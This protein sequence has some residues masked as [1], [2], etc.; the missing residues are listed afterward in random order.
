MFCSLLLPLTLSDTLLIFLARFLSLTGSL[1]LSLARMLTP[2]GSLWLY[3]APSGSLWLPLTHSPALS[4]LLSV[5]HWPLWLTIALLLHTVLARL[6]R[7]LLGSQRRYHAD[8]LF[9]S[10]FFLTKPII[11]AQ[12]SS[13]TFN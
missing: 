11:L 5:S 3:L 1:W 12:G 9:S 10:L 4:G 13:F 7:L 6:I 2:T 8:A